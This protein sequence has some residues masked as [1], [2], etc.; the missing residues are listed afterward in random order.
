[1]TP[2]DFQLGII[3]AGVL[4]N[5]PLVAYLLLM[6]HKIEIRVVRIETRLT[7][8]KGTENER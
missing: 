7:P 1:M 5:L 6:I 2:E 4:I 8:K 3:S